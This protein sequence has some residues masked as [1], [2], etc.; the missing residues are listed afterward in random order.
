MEILFHNETDVDIEVYETVIKDVLDEAVK[1]EGLT[2]HYVCH[3]IFVDND[4]IKKM[5]AYYRGK[6]YPTDVLTFE[7]EEEPF[8]NGRKNLGD[9]FV[10]IDKMIEQAYEYGHGE[11]RE[12]SFLAVHGFLHLLGYDHLDE[13]GEKEMFAKQEA[14][15]NA[16]DI[17]R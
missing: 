17:R 6:D 10:S 7:A 1:V 14:I 15:L 11:V 5:N 13:A 3:Y 2:D 12:M 4:K 8:F 16:K 9:V